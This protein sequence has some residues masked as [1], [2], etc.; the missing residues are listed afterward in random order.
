MPKHDYTEAE[1]EGYAE[2]MLKAKECMENQELYE[3]VNAHMSEKAQ[4]IRSIADLRKRINEAELSAEPYERA[5][6]ESAKRDGY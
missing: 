3:A 4:K 2:A 1:L 5:A 6:R